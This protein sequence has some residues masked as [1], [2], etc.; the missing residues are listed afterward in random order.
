M[1]IPAFGASFVRRVLGVFLLGF[2][3]ACVSKGG[4]A[5][6]QAPAADELSKRA[7]ARFELALAYYAQG[8]YEVA[9]EELDKSIKADDGL[10]A[11]HNL[12]GLALGALGRDELADQSFRRALQLAPQD[13]DALQNYAWF[14]C[15][16]GRYAQAQGLFTQVLKVPYYRDV[17][18]TQL[19]MGVCQARS[20]ALREAEAT[21]MQ[22]Y[23]REPNNPAVMVNLAEVLYRMGEYERAR[24]QMRR[25]HAVSD[26]VSAQTLWLALRIEHRLSQDAA[27]ASLAQQLRSRFPQAPEVAL[28]DRR[29]FDD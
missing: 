9:L 17:S 5:G 12:R 13:V 18:R 3:A 23:E 10:A 28:L 26:W 7:K 15:Q 2:L 24:F 20:G 21:L 6:A 19:T 8:Q 14:S 1:S 27:V 29:K 22:L 4:E 11:V 16:R 25:I